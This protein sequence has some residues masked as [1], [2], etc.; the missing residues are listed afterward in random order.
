MSQ[1][2]TKKSDEELM[3]DLKSDK[4]EA[5]DLLY[6]EHAGRILAW[7]KKKGLQQELAEELVQVVF[8][9]LFRR[10]SLYDPQYRFLQWL[11]VIAS[12]QLIDLR[13]RES[14]HQHVDLEDVSHFL[15]SDRSRNETRELEVSGV[16]EQE[17]KLLE[18][19]YVEDK[20]FSEISA[21]VG[22]SE[23]SLRQQISRLLRRLK[24]ES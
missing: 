24:G 4:L 12:T 18:L 11:Y 19:R 17:K 1:I 9:K 2:G 23:A 6:A 21:L 22:R 15:E 14:R 13:R 16:S 5:F 7:A 3:L 20:S 8:D 10:R